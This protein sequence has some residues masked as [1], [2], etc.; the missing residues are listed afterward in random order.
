MHTV[1]VRRLWV[2]G[3][4]EVSGERWNGVL[5]GGMNLGMQEGGT[6]S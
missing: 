5:E 6:Q 3:Q 1:M 4:C 2:Y